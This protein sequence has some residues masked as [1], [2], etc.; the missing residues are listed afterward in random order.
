MGKYC[1]PVL[2]QCDMWSV[3]TAVYTGRKFPMVEILGRVLSVGPVLLRC[4]M[5][6]IVT[7]I[8]TGRNL[9][10]LGKIFHVGNIAKFQ[11]YC[12]VNCEI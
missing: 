6:N 9:G 12:D 10:I 1:I 5:W 2:L 8:F 4:D 7:A 3:V 11:F